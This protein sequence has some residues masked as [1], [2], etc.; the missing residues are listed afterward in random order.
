MSFFFSFLGDSTIIAKD[1][2]DNVV[3]ISDS[4]PD[5][6]K[7]EVEALDGR[8]H[9]HTST[10]YNPI[11][12]LGNLLGMGSPD[13]EHTRRAHFRGTVSHS[14]MDKPPSL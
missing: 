3:C 11:A 4:I 8:G 7:L 13:R 6:M 5:K 9:H 14:I 12:A 1:S 10:G 2:N